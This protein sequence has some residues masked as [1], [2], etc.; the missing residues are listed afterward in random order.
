MI[1]NTGEMHSRVLGHKTCIRV[2]ESLGLNVFHLVH[3]A[4]GFCPARR[5]KDPRPMPHQEPLLPKESLAA[6]APS[7]LQ[8][9]LNVKWRERAAKLRNKSSHRR[10]A[11]Q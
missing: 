3:P 9:L 11:V 6:A 4:S 10:P 5:T 2:Q 7:D 8:V 1:S